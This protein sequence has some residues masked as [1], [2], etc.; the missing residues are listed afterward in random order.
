MSREEDIHEVLAEERSRGQRRPR[1]TAAGK[2][3]QRRLQKCRELLSSGCDEREFIEAIREA[4]LK[5]DS[6]EFQTALKIWRAL[7]RS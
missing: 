7:R 5:D 2:E 1:K 4:G 6:P 3:Y